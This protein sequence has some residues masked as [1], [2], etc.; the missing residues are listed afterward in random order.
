[1]LINLMPISLVTSIELVKIIQ[2]NLIQGDSI[3]RG[4]GLSKV[5]VM[6]SN[7]ID[8]LGQINMGFLDKTGTL[9]KN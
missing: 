7:L 5:Q 4:Q 6:N 2:A 9:T 1:M 8:N 3:F